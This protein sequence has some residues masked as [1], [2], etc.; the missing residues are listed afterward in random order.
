MLALPLQPLLPTHVPLAWIAAALL[1]LA[2]A[3]RA[4]LTND[5]RYEGVDWVLVR[6]KL[7]GYVSTCVGRA[8]DA[9]DIVHTVLMRVLAPDARP[10]DRQKQSILMYLGSFANTEIW[11]LRN[12]ADRKQSR[13]ELTEAI[14]GTRAAEGA[15]PFTP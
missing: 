12:S 8:F 7:R 5:P 2:L 14:V 3:A 11:N 10:W 15:T 13:F 6:D 1:A 9:D 4:S